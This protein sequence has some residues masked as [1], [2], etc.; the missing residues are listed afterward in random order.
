MA[1]HFAGECLLMCLDS[2]RARHLLGVLSA[3]FPPWIHNI[4]VVDYEPTAESS[5]PNKSCDVEISLKNL[6]QK[7]CFVCKTNSVCI[8]DL[9]LWLLESEGNC[10]E[11]R[12]AGICL[13]GSQEC[14]K[15]LKVSQ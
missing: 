12:R 15:G 8:T 10:F 2:W 6:W 13:P 5:N 9:T 1:E 7:N 14:S 11:V 4:T 3:L